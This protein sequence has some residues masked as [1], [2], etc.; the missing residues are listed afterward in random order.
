M[1][2]VV[3]I[4]NTKWFVLNF[5]EWLVKELIKK[6]KVEIF[7]IKN[8]PPSHNDYLLKENNLKFIKLNLKSF[9]EILLKFK[10][11][12][13]LF[14]FTIYGI[15]LSPIF[16]PNA[17]Q[18]I[19]TIEGFGRLFSSSSNSDI[20]KK[21]VLFI[22]K[23]I[24]KHYY[25]KIFVLNFSDIKYLLDKK[26][27][28]FKKIKYL[29]GTGINHKFFSRDTKKNKLLEPNNSKFNIGMIS[30][31]IPEKGI[32]TFIASKFALIRQFNDL[33]IKINYI[34]F[35]PKKDLLKLS[36]NSIIELEKHNIKISQYNKNPLATYSQ[37]DILVQPSTYF[38]GLNRVILEAGCLQI[39]IITCKNRGIID[40]IP[41]ENYGYLL[42]KDSFPIEICQN[43]QNIITD[44][45]NAINKSENLRNH[46][47]KN[48]NEKIISDLFFEQITL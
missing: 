8:G 37:I 20:K 41:N 7:F 5:K 10:K 1:E 32:N 31:N 34:I 16:F 6:Y 28:S 33:D 25:D 42:D 39:P 48:F 43:I 35:M 9:F 14:S 22:Y 38:E 44:P 11:P 18:K 2:K 30:R 26:I 36:K 46:I 45:S 19:A 27:V 13:F 29:P 23:N 21:I 4:A 3:I 40:I 24:F 47:V 12:K 15:I 17:S